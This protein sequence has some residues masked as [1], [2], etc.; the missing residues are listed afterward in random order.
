MLNAERILADKAVRPHRMLTPEFWQGEI[1]APARECIARYGLLRV[2]YGA[3]A[4]TDYLYDPV[5]PSQ[6]QSQSGGW[7]QPRGGSL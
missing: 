4:I 2:F 3:W 7:A 1:T 6:R 5:I